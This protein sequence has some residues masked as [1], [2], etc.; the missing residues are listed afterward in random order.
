[1]EG[2]RSRR[3]DLYVA[4]PGRDPLPLWAPVE[5]ALVLFRHRAHSSCPHGA[6]H[7]VPGGTGP[8]L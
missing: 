8:V 2:A 7:P 1:M 3:R 5:F 4:E 6:K